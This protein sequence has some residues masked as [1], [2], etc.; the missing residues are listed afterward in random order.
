MEEFDQ[1]IKEI[2][3][4]FIGIKD[5]FDDNAKAHEQLNSLLKQ[6]DEALM[7][8]HDRISALEVA[9]M[10]IPSPEKTYYKPPGTDEY[11]N[12]KGNYDYIYERL[13]KLEGK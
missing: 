3:D 13:A 2:D 8:L 1:I 12:V 6:V 5:A 7:A 9:V 10:E 4:N 11:L